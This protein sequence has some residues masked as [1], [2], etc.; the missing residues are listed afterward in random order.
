MKLLTLK[1]YVFFLIIQM[2]SRVNI[3]KFF[4][5]KYVRLAFVSRNVENRTIL[6]DETK[7]K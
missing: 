1:I 2:L 4:A 6:D 5:S 7:K 3:S